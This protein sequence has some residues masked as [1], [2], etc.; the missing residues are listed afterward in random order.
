MTAAATV[1]YFATLK[2]LSRKVAKQR[3]YE[4]LERYGLGEF[5]DTKVQA[6]SK[7]MAQRSR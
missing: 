2:G 3:A 1:A 4:L 6:L 5:A 7:G